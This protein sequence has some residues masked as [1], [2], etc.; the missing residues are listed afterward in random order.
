MTRQASAILSAIEPETMQPGDGL[1]KSILENS[2]FGL[3][4]LEGNGRIV[5]WNNWLA[6]TSGI[7]ADQA[8]GCELTELFPE[9]QKSR[10]MAAV[11]AALERGQS[12]QLSRLLNRS[13]LPL[14]GDETHERLHQTIILQ[15]LAT[16]G[17]GCQI[18]IFDATPEAVREDKLKEKNQRLSELY[19]TA[20]RFVDNVSHEFR[21]P[22]TVIKEFTSIILDGLAGDISGQQRD[23]LKIV[24]NRADDLAVMVDDMLDI[25]KLEVGALSVARTQCRV[26]QIIERIIATLE[27]KAAARN[28]TFSVEIDPSLPHAYCD[29]EKI[30]RV[31]INLVIN[32]LKFSDA[33]GHTK[34]TVFPRA[35]K[36]EIV[37]CITDDGPGISPENLQEI[38][39]RFKQVNGNVRTGAKGFGLG[40]NIAKELVH[41]NFGEI[42]VNSELGKGSS[43][44]FTVPSFDPPKILQRFL[45]HVE[46]FRD[47]SS[48][49][50]LFTAE[51]Q[52]PVDSA[53]HDGVEQ[54]LQLQL[55][56]SSLLICPR[57][58]RWLLAIATNI[59]ES[60]QVIAR[61]EQ[62]LAQANRECP[63]MELP[64]IDLEIK[65][66]WRVQ[67]QS[68]EFIRRFE[69]EYAGGETHA[70]SAPARLE[71]A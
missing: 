60:E 30:G 39:E 36:S 57:P 65:E 6:S 16:G 51:I 52:T 28:V 2:D 71:G 68:S 31:I 37:F 56:R 42:V 33:G 44:T 59:G 62:A 12:A 26:E 7:D 15:P 25:S 47:E 20:H 13:P 1:F 10:L 64:A 19:D 53:A 32:A 55:R 21:S 23:Y 9:L 4:V 46:H 17:S 70:V 40:L 5:F 29:A 27:T 58:G 8:H 24:I 66:S 54:F 22:L 69:A 38:F 43:F 49:V 61:L 3:I 41:L 11:T 67:D 35:E 34:L 63:S 50:S 18:Q 48:H 14:Y 45:D